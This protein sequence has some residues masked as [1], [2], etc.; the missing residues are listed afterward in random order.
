MKMKWRLKKRNVYGTDRNTIF[1]MR[2]FSDD[3]PIFLCVTLIIFFKKHPSN[4]THS[5]RFDHFGRPKR[6]SE[7]NVSIYDTCMSFVNVI[8]LMHINHVFAYCVTR[9][10]S[11]RSIS[12]VSSF[13]RW[14]LIKLMGDGKMLIHMN[15]KWFLQAC[16]HKICF[17]ISLA[18]QCRSR[19]PSISFDKI[20]HKFSYFCRIDIDSV[21]RKNVIHQHN[22]FHLKYFPTE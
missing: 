22:E 13:A 14:R 2:H 15:S 1:Q 9:Y 19:R 17:Y 18:I 5:H 4:W 8:C 11:K 21:D 7:L 20:A 6:Q 3:A 12:S 16:S 10:T